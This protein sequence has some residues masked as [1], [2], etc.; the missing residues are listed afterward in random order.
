MA[1]K[2]VALFVDV[3][4]LHQHM[5]HLHNRTL[6]PKILVETAQAQ[7][8]RGTERQARASI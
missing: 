5:R 2:K 8:E 6:D 7:G 1:A 3:D 4:G